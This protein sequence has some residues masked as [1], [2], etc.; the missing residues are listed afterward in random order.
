[1]IT[2][3][4]A[5]AS[6]HVPHD[7]VVA[8]AAP[9]GDPWWTLVNRGSASLL[10]RSDDAG[11]T[12]AF[13]GGAPT[14]DTLVA[15]AALDDGAIVLVG[16][17]WL[18]WSADGATWDHG[19]LPGAVDRA[20]GGASL[21][22]AGPG[23]LFEGSPDG[24]A[25]VT[26]TPMVALAAG[27]GGIAAIDGRH[28]VWLGRDG[29]WETLS[30]PVNPTAALLDDT[31]WIGTADGSVYRLD[32]TRWPKAADRPA[33]PHP[34]ILG[35]AAAD[36]LAVVD[37]DGAL[38]RSA[39]DG[40]SWVDQEAPLAIQ[41]G[42]DGGASG[43]DEGVTVLAAA[44]DGWVL[45]GWAGL[46]VGGP[47][48]WR[49]AA[50]LPPEY[51]RGIAFSPDFDRDGTLVWGTYSGGIG[52]S[53]DGGS[54]WEFA[55]GLLAPNVQALEVPTPRDAWAI[56]G[57]HLVRG[58][59]RGTRWQAAGSPFLQDEQ[60]LVLDDV[61]VAGVD[62]NGPGIATPHGDSWDRVHLP[63]V[64]TPRNRVRI[65]ALACVGTF[66]AE[67]AC[68]DDDGATWGLRFT[69]S[70]RMTSVRAWP[71]DDPT[72]LVLADEAGVHASDDGGGSWSTIPL[73]PVD[74]PE[75][76]A[77]ADDGTLFLATASARLYRSDDGGD[78]WTDLGIA[79]PA[80]V[81]AIAARPGFD[82]PDLL[83]ATPAGVFHVRAD[84]PPTVARF[85]GWEHV[86]AGAS[87]FT[88]CPL[89]PESEPLDGAS[90]GRVQPVPAGATLTTTVRGTS[91][92]ITGFGGAA[93]LQIDDVDL[94]TLDGDGPELARVD[95]LADGPHRVAI[96]GTSGD[97]VRID[98][99]DA[100]SPADGLDFGGRGCG[101]GGGAACVTFVTT[102]C[103][104]RR[105]G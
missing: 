18:W 35:I 91:V 59:R 70:G 42:G 54:S 13:A 30:P 51:T 95:G 105:R 83:V 90:L 12:W 85:G 89:C 73:D 8:A 93:T 81:T 80:S 94:A 98:A 60:V 9:A 39:D 4:C 15:A 16:T 41:Y 2:M 66:A 68:T 43:L 40:A 62:A 100:T 76:L 84:D 47:G 52:V 78:G 57:H 21:V 11:D 36:G 86:D 72:R 34:A 23:G 79:L 32:G 67:L 87:E 28:R 14:A 19:P 56:V 104:R 96:V 50:L 75:E 29:A 102:A 77:L 24:M 31:A 65:G 38:W 45:G 17:R 82:P 46:A 27:P 99:I 69:G 25:L 97:G 71:P 58:D 37:G 5:L 7:Q 22:L 3:F 103:R 33:G 48:D 63:V 64:D 49:P 53:T 20:A 92:A 55:D 74:P 61:W 1:M 10:L 101:H 88:D 6:A 44:G 26:A